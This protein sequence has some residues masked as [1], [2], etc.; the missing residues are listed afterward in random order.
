MSQI[1]D[2]KRGGLGSYEDVCEEQ[3]LIMLEYLTV[4]EIIAFALML[5][6]IPHALFAKEKNTLESSATRMS[7]INGAPVPVLVVQETLKE[8]ANILQIKRNNGPEES[9]DKTAAT[10]NI[11]LKKAEDRGY[12]DTDKFFYR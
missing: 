3:Y 2:L 9:R 4:A 5:A 6:K 1:Y 7:G 8:I 11:F 10:V 12:K